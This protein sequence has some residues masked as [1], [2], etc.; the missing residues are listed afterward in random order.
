MPAELKHALDFLRD[1]RENNDREWF[2]ANKKRYEKA[3]TAFE[4]VV[5][6]VIERF[7]AVDDLGGVTLP[8]TLYRI[9]RDVR[10]SPDKSPYKTHFGALLGKEG[11]KSTGRVYYIQIMPYNQSMVAGGLY[12]IYPAQLDAVRKA[13]A[14]DDRPLR[15]ILASESFK[16]YFNGL[17]GEQLKSAPKGYAKDHHAIELLR[18]KQFTAGHT[19][20]DDQ[21]L[22][23]NLVDHI[24]EACTALK[25]FNTY[26]YDLIE[27]VPVPE[28]M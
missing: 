22:S 24:L 12:M 1:L 5:A 9:N 23:D 21:V 20:T 3:R 10:F 4:D 7:D 26:V 8:E 14:E 28:R 16:K 19:M 15:K 18:Y 27:G 13:I 17:E 25:P 6:Q 2:N 11:R